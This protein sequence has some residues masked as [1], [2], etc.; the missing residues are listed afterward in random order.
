MPRLKD[1]Y[2]TI[3]LLSDA[4]LLDLCEAVLQVLG[5][6]LRAPQNAECAHNFLSNILTDYDRSELAALACSEAWGWLYSNG[7]ICHHPINDS[8]W[9]TLSRLGRKH[10]EQ[11]TPL[12]SWIEDRQLPEELLHPSLR[13]A[14]LNLFKQ[15]M[16]D[17]AVFESLKT[18]EV[19][20]RKVALLSDEWIDLSSLLMLLLP[21]L[22]H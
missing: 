8:P 16:Y 18:L 14:A 2:P 20:I 21:K 22:D 3:A 5:S 15:E 17:T 4:P 6:Q 9:M 11:S 12:K 1:L 10:Y 19:S 13:S 7:F